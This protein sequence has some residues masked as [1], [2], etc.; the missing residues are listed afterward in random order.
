MSRFISAEKEEDHKVRVCAEHLRQYSE[1]LNL[2]STIR[3]RDAFSFLSK[4]LEEEKKKKMSPDELKIQI[5]D[6]ERFL[7]SLFDGIVILFVV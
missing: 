5:T 6:T 1:G 4:Y 3:M 7:F 2:S